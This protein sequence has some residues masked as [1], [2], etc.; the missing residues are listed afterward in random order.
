MTPTSPIK[1]IQAALERF[2]GDDLY[3]A[4]LAFKSCTPYEMQ[5]QYGHSGQTRAQ[6]LAGYEEHEAEVDAALEWLRQV[7]GGSK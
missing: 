1:T 6:I 2:R 5:Q 7:T 4:R 3:R